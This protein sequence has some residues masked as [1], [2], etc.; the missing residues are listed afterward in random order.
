MNNRKINKLS[1][2]III[3][4]VVSL[5]GSWIFF[6]KDKLKPQTEPEPEVIVEPVVDTEIERLKDVW[7]EN[8]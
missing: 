6:L 1:I 5:A 4:L 3:F 8:K 7:Q 2:F